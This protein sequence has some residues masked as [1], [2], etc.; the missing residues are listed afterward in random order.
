[1][2]TKEYLDHKAVV[3]LIILTLFWGFNHPAIKISNQGV[4][5]IFASTLRSTIASIC[6][7]IYCLTKEE[8]VFRRGVMLFH[9]M[10]VDL[11]FGADFPCI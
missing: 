9:G 10:M 8:K 1:M 2:K 3:I 7:L 11:L 4:S 5:P 6:G